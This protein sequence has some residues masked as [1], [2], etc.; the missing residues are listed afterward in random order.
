MISQK[1]TKDFRRMKEMLGRVQ[2][3]QVQHV[4]GILNTWTASQFQMTHLYKHTQSG[5]WK[6]Q[7]RDPQTLNGVGVKGLVGERRR[8]SLLWLSPSYR[9]ETKANN[10]R[11]QHISHTHVYR[12]TY[13]SGA[14]ADISHVVHGENVEN[15]LFQTLVPPAVSNTLLKV[16]CE[17]TTST[18]HWYKLWRRVIGNTNLVLAVLRH[19]CGSLLAGVCYRWLLRT[20]RTWRSIT[21]KW[22]NKFIIFT[23]V[24]PR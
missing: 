18:K 20:R 23:S 1:H 3:V 8:K 10:F 14:F 22:E 24:S 11:R 21:H 19:G 2:C 7:H 12:Q 15:S 6:A 17:L 5:K 13:A 9:E 16:D 4:G